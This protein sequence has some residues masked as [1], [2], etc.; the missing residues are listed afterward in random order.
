[1]N[2]VNKVEKPA[3][4]LALA[5]IVPPRQQGDQAATH[6]HALNFPS[7]LQVESTSVKCDTFSNQSNGGALPANV[8]T[9]RI[10]L[11]HDDSRGHCGSLADGAD[12]ME[13]MVFFEHGRVENAYL[14]SRAR[15]TE[16]SGEIRNG[17]RMKDV[18]A[19]VA[20]FSSE[21]GSFGQ[22]SRAIGSLQKPRNDQ[23]PG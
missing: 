5:P 21:N 13:I 3:S 22:R 14:D 11:E 17:L 2:N 8:A 10:P 19:L 18:G 15:F 23:K 1:M 20:E 9:W 4:K 7:T 16:R 12:Q 6:M